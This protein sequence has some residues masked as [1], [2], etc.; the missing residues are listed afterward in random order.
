MN[1]ILKMAWRDSR[2][3]RARLFLFISAITA[4]IAALTAVRSFSV[5]LTADIDREAKTLLGADLLLGANQPAADSTLALFDLPGTER[6]QVTNFVSM[7]RFAS[8]GGTRLSQIRALEGNYPFFGIWKSEPVNA[9]KSFR[10]GKKALI[11]HALALQFNIKAGD[12]IQ[13]GNVTFLVE[14]ELLSS[15]GRAGVASAIAPVVF[16]P[17]SWLDSTGLIQRG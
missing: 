4:G 17:A 2:R 11:D 3:N 10:T 15:P 6:A 14:G 7:V 5:N 1:F 9:W 13:V 8:N 12:S 16:I